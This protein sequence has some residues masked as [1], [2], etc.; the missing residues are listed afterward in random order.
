MKKTFGIGVQLRDIIVSIIEIY[1]LKN[2][3][4][5]EEIESV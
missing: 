5:K 3:S 4:S 2:P 1:L